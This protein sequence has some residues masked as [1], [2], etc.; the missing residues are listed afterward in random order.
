M[1]TRGHFRGHPIYSDGEWRFCDTD[2][3]TETT[4]KSRPCGHCGLMYPD[5]D[6]PDPCLGTLPGV[7]NACCGHGNRGQSYIQFT[8]GVVVRGFDVIETDDKSAWC[9]EED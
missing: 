3:P 5:P 1:T 4:W 8:N 7:R 9:G 6:G 2:E